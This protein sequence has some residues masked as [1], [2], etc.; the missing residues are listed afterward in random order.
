ME[1]SW[2]E[3]NN[4]LYDIKEGEGYN[5]V[6]VTKRTKTKIHLSNNIIIH[7]KKHLIGFIYLDSK[8]VRRRNKSYPL[9]NRVLRDIEGYL[10][11]KKLTDYGRFS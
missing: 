2:I 1:N 3:A 10:I 8:S 6:V 4:Y 11:Y 5:D 9:V 7:I